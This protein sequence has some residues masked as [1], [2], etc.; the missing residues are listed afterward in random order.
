MVKTEKI[1]E[2]EVVQ[3]SSAFVRIVGKTTLEIINAKQS[4]GVPKTVKSKWFIRET[5]GKKS[6]VFSQGDKKY[7][8]IEELRNREIALKAA[9]QKKT[10]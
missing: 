10:T 2:T 4:D 7:P 9:A 6:K 1:E 5:V 3:I 8:L